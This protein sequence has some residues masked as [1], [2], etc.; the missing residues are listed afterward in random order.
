MSS[1]QPKV[2]FV[3]ESPRPLFTFIF[4]RRCL[5]RARLQRSRWQHL[6]LGAW[7]LRM[8]SESYSSLVGAVV[9][10]I[11]TKLYRDDG[12]SNHTPIAK[13]HRRRNFWLPFIQTQDKGYLEIN[14]TLQPSM[15]I[16]KKSTDSFSAFESDISDGATVKS[17]AAASSV[18][19]IEP[20]IRSQSSELDGDM[21]DLLVFTYIYVE[22]LRKDREQAMHPKDPWTVWGMIHA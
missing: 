18:A 13:Y 12:T 9:N 1:Y 6:S 5:Q 14:A 11:L 2:D 7:L 10:G 19:D 4:E 21:L 22:K 20:L 17:V 16:D 3:G 8:H 15:G